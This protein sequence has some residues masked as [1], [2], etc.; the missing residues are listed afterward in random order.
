[1]TEYG[2]DSLHIAVGPGD[3]AIHL[4]VENP[5]APKPKI[6]R[7]IL[8]D[9]GENRTNV[10]PNIKRTMDQIKEKYT[11][12]PKNGLTFDSIIITHWDSDHYEGV[13][14]LIE[15]DIKTQLNRKTPKPP[16]VDDLRVS[17]LKYTDNDR[18]KPATVFY[19]PYWDAEL[20]DGKTVKNGNPAD[21]RRNESNNG[22]LD[23]R[24]K[25]KKDENWLTGICLLETENLLGFNFLTAKGLPS[26]KKP[27]DIT[28]PADLL[29]ANKPDAGQ[30][31]IY[32]IAS[33]QRVLGK[34]KGDFFIIDTQITKTNQCSIC[35][36]VIWA[37]GHISHYFGGDADYSTERKITTWSKTDGTEAIGKSVTTMKLSHHGAA[38]STP[39]DMLDKFNPR[40][41]V[42][43]CGDGYGHPR[44]ELML[45]LYAWILAKDPM[46]TTISKPVFA[47]QYP[48][49][50]ARDGD[51][52]IDTVGSNKPTV[53]ASD[54]PS[55]AVNTFIKRLKSLYSVINEGMKASGGVEMT[56]IYTQFKEWK[57]KE[58]G[59]GDDK[60]TLTDLEQLQW[61]L[62]QVASCWNVLSH[63]PETTHPASSAAFASDGP[64]PVLRS[65]TSVQYIRVACR[66]FGADGDVFVKI[67]GHPDETVYWNLPTKP[68][69]SA[70][71]TDTKA[72]KKRK[73][74][75]VHS[76][77]DPKKKK[78][79]GDG[80]KVLTT[81]KPAIGVDPNEKSDLDTTKLHVSHSHVLHFQEAV[82]L[83]EEHMLADDEGFYFYCSELDVKG[84]NVRILSVGNLDDFVTLLH[85]GV[86]GLESQP[87]AESPA[88]LLG[89]D[90]WLCWFTDCIDATTLSAIGDQNGN[91]NGFNLAMTSPVKS[92]HPSLLPTAPDIRFG[93]SF[94]DYAFGLQ[95]NLNGIP[96]P[97]L[98]GEVDILVFGLDP[99]SSTLKMSLPQVF[100]YVG[101]TKLA[102][103]PLIKLLGDF[104]VTLDPKDSEG[105]RN[106]VWFDPTNNYKTVV[107]FQFA[108]PP[109]SLS[110]ISNFL[111]ILKDFNVTGA[112]VI[113]K[114][115]ATWIPG[116]TGVSIMNDAEV[117][118][119]V[120]CKVTVQSNIHEFE[121]ALTFQ[122]T[123]LKLDLTTQSP[124]TFQDIIIWLGTLVGISSF[125]FTD[126]LKSAGSSFMKDLQLRR[127]SLAITLGEDQKPTI[128]NF[129][130]DMEI[131]LN[132]GGAGD[133]KS[134]LYL[135]TYSWVK[136]QKIGSL[137]GSLW[138]APPAFAVL[139]WPKL[140][141]DWEEH[142]D[143]KPI[144]KD[145][146][147]ETLDLAKM[148]PGDTN[149]VVNIPQGIPT[150][151]CQASLEIDD[152][153]IAFYGALSCAQPLK[154]NIPTIYLAK[155]GLG[156]KYIFSKD[157]QK[158]SFDLSFQME[159]LLQA[160]A[161]SLFQT[162]PAVML[163][164]IKY[165]SPEWHVSGSVENLY[166]S[167]LYSFFDSDSQD[168]VMTFLER[169]II[170][171]LS[172]QYNYDPVPNGTGK[173]FLFTGI[174]LLGGLELDLK[175][176]YDQKGWK[177]NAA[178][179]ASS[180]NK[181][182]SNIGQIVES[183]TGSSAD[184]PPFV[185]N[186]EV[187]KPK[188]EKD[189][190]SINCQKIKDDQLFFS[191][192][193]HIGP[194]EFTFAQYRNVNWKASVASK[195][196]IK[197][198][199]TALPSV[200]VPIIGNLTQPFDEMFYMWVQD[201]SGQ[202][203]AKASP[204]L[205][206]AEVKSINE[207][208]TGDKLLF[209]EISNNPNDKDVVIEAGS[210]F[211]LVLKNE[212]GDKKVVIDYVFGKPTPS[213]AESTG[214]ELIALGDDS[215]TSSDSSLAPYKKSIGPLSISNIGFQ[216]KGGVLSILL[217]AAF[218]LGP[219]GFILQG[220]SLGIKFDDET[221]LQ[222]LPS[223]LS[224]SLSGLAVSFDR[225][226]IVISGLY[227]YSKTDQLEYYAGGI[228]VAFAPYLFEAAGFYGM[229][230]SPGHEPFKSVFV[231]AKLDGPL[232]TLEFAE[233]SGITGG[234]GYNTDLQFP[235]VA[236]VRKF[237]FLSNG[238][239]PDTPMQ[240]LINLTKPG[241]WFNPRD[242][243]FWVAA[244]LK[245]TAFQTLSIDAVVVVEW[246]PYVNLGIFGVAVADIPGGKSTGEKFA[247]VELG[248]S[249]TVDF[250]AGVMKFEAQLSPN[251][252]ILSP[253]CHLTGGFALYYWFKGSDPKLEGD[254][255]FTIGGYHQAFKPPPQYPNPP[256]LAI[257]WS[258]DSSLSITGQAY[259]A[260]TP[261]VCMGGG[262]LHAA[263]SLGPL[264][265]FF[266]AYAD[267]LINYK[268]FNFM[269]DGGVSVGVRFTLDLWIVTVHISV[270]IGAQL[271]L[272]GPPLSG[273]V[274][275]DFWVFGF[276]I[277]FGPGAARIQPVKL[278][279]FYNLVLQS[280]APS[281]L[282][283]ANL[284]LTQTEE[285]TSEEPS[286]RPHVY[287][288]Q[289]GLVTGSGKQE[290]PEGE[291]W[292]VRAGSF[293]FGVSCRFAINSAT[294]GD[295]A[296]TWS[297]DIYAKP[298]Q[299]ENP[300][301]ST[302]KISIARTDEKPSSKATDPVW[303]I[304]RD[305]K[306]VPNALW[307]QYHP[308]EDPSLKGNNITSLLNGKDVATS[309]MMGVII[310]APDPELS[311]DVI[312]K[313]NAVKAMSQDVFGQGK[314][315]IFPKNLQSNQ[316]W[317][318]LKAVPGPNQ[319]KNVSDRWKN[320]IMGKTS[321]QNTVD[322][323]KK[324]FFWE[325]TLN[326]APP[327]KLLDDFGA[328]YL[329]VPLLSVL[330]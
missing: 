301:S 123:L 323:W 205:I 25:I 287:G 268:P 136:G 266:D 237:P 321:A 60:K 131:K 155:I 304:S 47:T 20:K 125:D 53:F 137:K 165:N 90:E 92:V 320:P 26:D 99:T 206:R 41:M 210:H 130:L 121:A 328:L 294:L 129:N 33:N 5:S 288:C 325:V 128:S 110:S 34:V 315:K 211:V 27:E 209:K 290:T 235:S 3:C 146:L 281:S 63:I 31:G 16:P 50:L 135:L 285:K 126:W 322:A 201:K 279:A 171:E 256:R 87:T 88:K 261:K 223:T 286:A 69:P 22:Q 145:K 200:E 28:S 73:S 4:L 229:V 102:Q 70:A 85:R 300:L 243:S 262:R 208:L 122:E 218:V 296:V 59:N 265:A 163:G 104:D 305:L 37:D 298:M 91:M 280:G 173:D 44:W 264:D 224:V 96:A 45:Y 77:S 183:I 117:I 226:P 242:G 326:G 260:I 297:T 213:Q 259:F 324:A 7:A 263:L 152:T 282:S 86:V 106:A 169:L 172:L 227:E 187:G 10:V 76:N 18:K 267:F 189:L 116:P 233:I 257:T 245:V 49:Y 269:A 148:I 249:V 317:L 176:N 65:K 228:I 66:K 58:E 248:I 141:P 29:E 8:I 2:V 314:E 14:K 166:A 159:A 30:P 178:L 284:F 103:T 93:T 54:S 308:D 161:D 225:P 252:Y 212:K 94:I 111:S 203:G 98:L 115:T 42:I 232:V 221:N 144:T 188:S 62:D 51:G 142:L 244:G 154:G 313:F 273:T 6:L 311:N 118:M 222:K 113:A 190:I 184:L 119:A 329:A 143:F 164:I 330:A 153:G 181:G 185:S 195:R 105:G 15:D 217:D 207:Q 175:F 251:S 193:V 289:S 48:Y 109:E 156:A 303:K 291:I 307:G 236:E 112:N 306:S 202:N 13:V 327:A 132:F 239:V 271:H 299:L 23:F 72:N 149:G 167:T 17:F 150:Q 82:R 46:K 35:A 107:R 182:T 79:K 101:L 38:S 274:H 253:N 120:K 220:F 318:P 254:W 100:A 40:N 78:K 295:A 246:N 147:S 108:V 258:L 43:S 293:S 194:L 283:G 24:Y 80:V 277:N 57:K 140:L 250:H 292:N 219:I 127:I 215:S 310:N 71:K 12:D 11:V 309:L 198:S 170:K 278:D 56:D 231:F 275:V 180:T 255:V 1:M 204:G 270:E 134:V 64:T 240:T 247:H 241:G 32:C 89:T 319:W 316:I 162:S 9:G 67:E 83:E 39:F 196:V 61:I 158:S 186:I 84:P 199:V 179:G 19:A 75:A 55:S 168:G 272:V 177:F 238:P 197:V 36:M 52:Y 276:D 302:M 192:S 74:V 312:P 124:G 157:D 114:K 160:K 133:D 214:L 230:N 81:Y 174:I 68:A 216:Y 95:T 151:I 21:L 139:P 234:F 97:G 191:A 138:C